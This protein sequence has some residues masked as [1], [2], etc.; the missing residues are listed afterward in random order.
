MI[1]KFSLYNGGILWSFH[2]THYFQ[3]RYSPILV[4]RAIQLAMLA[5]QRL[6]LQCRE[7]WGQAILV[8]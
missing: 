4:H 3:G 2:L 6:P 7:Q 8:R 1:W 5:Y